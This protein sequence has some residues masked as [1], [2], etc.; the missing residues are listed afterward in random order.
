MAADEPND[1][2]SRLARE[3][4]QR[5]ESL[6]RAGLDRIPV[7]VTWPSVPASAHTDTGRAREE[8]EPRRPVAGPRPSEP[9]AARVEPPPPL[10]PTPP[11]PQAR[12]ASLFDEPEIDAPVVPPAERP[13]RLAAL[14]AEVA[15]CTRCPLLASS[16][17]QT[18]FGVGS[19]TA[20]LMFIGEAPGAD[21]DRTGVPFVGRAGMLL[22]DMI[23][24]GMGL[25]REEVYIANILKSR[26]PGNRDP[27]PDEVANCRP[28]LERQIAIIRPEFLCLLGRVAASS[29]L[30]TALPLGKLRG[31]WHRY[32]GI[33]TL[34]TYHPAYLLRNPASK[35]E[36]WDDLQTLMKAMGI[37][38]PGRKRG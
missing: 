36:A 6:R 23:V 1:G 12:N 5:L 37:N 7:S 32:C 13:A 26:P 2:H 4:R 19:P 14:A 11:L 15:A 24:K 10:A 20:R 25:T 22:T 31:R 8:S 30:D 9:V 17:T 3:L 38:P 27:L 16:R 28:F 35:K 18:V 21:E 33:P 34:V 29:L